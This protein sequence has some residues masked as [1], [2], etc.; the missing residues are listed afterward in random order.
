MAR[1]VKSGS[2]VV[3][4]SCQTL[5]PAR[6]PSFSTE[7]ESTVMPPAFFSM[8]RRSPSK[9]F[10]AACAFGQGSARSNDPNTISVSGGA[11][12]AVESKRWSVRG[13]RRCGGV[14]FG[15]PAGT[16][17]LSPPSRVRCPYASSS[18][19]AAPGPNPS[20][21]RTSNGGAHCL[22]PSWSVAPLATAHV[23]R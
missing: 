15:A 1:S 9:A 19:V 7:S 8:H 17:V 14:E 5:G 21:E 12:G 3:C 18:V 4:R 22:A 11:S 20:I 6:A 23:K 16:K 13:R 2:A 10:V